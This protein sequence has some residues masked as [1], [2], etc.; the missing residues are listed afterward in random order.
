MPNNL[1]LVSGSNTYAGQVGTVYP[2]TLN[3]SVNQTGNFKAILDGLNGNADLQLQSSSGTV[4]R[5]SSLTGTTPEEINF[6]DLAAGE[7][8]LLV[9]SAGDNINY[10]LSLTLEEVASSEK[11]VVDP[12][13]GSDYEPSTTIISNNSSEISTDSPDLITGDAVEN[14]D[15]ISPSNTLTGTTDETN[16]TEEFTQTD[17][18]LGITSETEKKLG[19]SLATPEEYSNILTTPE[20]E[21]TS[22]QSII[23]ESEI[24]D[25]L[26]EVATTDS[27]ESTNPDELEITSETTN[28]DD[29][30]ITSETTNSDD[31]VITS[32]TTNSQETTISTSV[33]DAIT[34][35]VESTEIGNWE[36]NQKETIDQLT[37]ETIAL[38]IGSEIEEEVISNQV[39]NSVEQNET[40][41]TDLTESIAK[42][43]REESS[44]NSTNNDSSA[45]ISTPDENQDL[46]AEEET[47]IET[48][49]AENS[50]IT[51]PTETAIGDNLT[52]EEPVENSS[53]ISDASTEET[54]AVNGSEEDQKAE[55]EAEVSTDETQQDLNPTTIQPE[56]TASPAPFISGKFKVDTTGKVGIDFLLDG[57]FYKGQLAIFSLKGMEKFVPGSEEFIKEATARALSQSV[58][59]HVVIYDLTE[60]ARFSGN[61]GEENY[62]TGEYL[63]VKTFDMTPGD[64][65]GVML[66]PNG[67]VQE[68]FDN[69][70]ISGDKRPLFSMATANPLHGMQIGQIADVTGEGNTFSMEDLRI[71]GWIDRD[72]NDFVFQVRG[73][74]GK[75]VL[76]DDVVAEGK[77]WRTS[78]LGKA[79]VAYAKPYITPEPAEDLE[80]SLSGLLEDLEDVT[81]KPETSTKELLTEKEDSPTTEEFIEQSSAN[82][83]DNSTSILPSDNQESNPD[84]QA[85]TGGEEDE[86][87][88]ELPPT[89]IPNSATSNT[90]FA[91]DQTED[92]NSEPVF[93]TQDE[94]TEDKP[95]LTAAFEVEKAINTE[96]SL[97]QP[98][99]VETTVNQSEITPTI[100]SKETA[101][102]PD[103]VVNITV[104]SNPPSTQVAAPT[105]ASMLPQTKEAIADTS[106]LT[107]V[108]EVV[109]PL[110]KETV[111][112]I[113]ENTTTSPVVNTSEANAGSN[114][115]SETVDNSVDNLPKKKTENSTNS[116]EDVTPTSEIV[117]EFFEPE[118]ETETQGFVWDWS[119]PFMEEAETELSIINPVN[120]ELIYR[121]ETLSEILRNQD[122][123]IS[124]GGKAVNPALIE[125]LDNIAANLRNQSESNVNPATYDATANLISRLEDMVARVAPVPIEYVEPVQ[126]AFP[127]SSQP[128]VGIIDTGFN[129][130][131]PDIDYSRIILGRDRVSN[132]ENPL[133]A[134]GEGSEHGT[135]ILGILGA[136]QNNGIGID[137]VNDIA[138]LW[139]GRAI[140]SGKWAES[141]V[142]FVDKLRE[143]GQPNGVVNLSLDLTQINPDG[144]VTT[145]YEFTPEERS[146]IEYARQ[147]H[148]LLV[149][150]S[151]NDGSVMSALGQGSQEFDNIITVGAAKRVNDEIALSK[152]YDRADYSSY[153]RGLDIMADG[154]TVENPVFS[155]TGDG[156]GAMAGTSVATA[157]VTGAV[158][159]MWAANPQ[160]SYRQVIDILKSTATDLKEPNWDEETGAGLLNMAA[161]VGL[162]GVTTGEVYQPD[163][164]FT[165]DTWSGEGLAIA[166]ERATATEFMGKYYEWDSYTIKPGDTLSAIAFS[167]MGNSSAPYYN[168][169][170]EKNGIT[171]PNLIYVGQNIGSFGILW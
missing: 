40:N 42:E 21:S 57:G 128:L 165:P 70:A 1:G 73:A 134:T 54:S 169:I 100:E 126:F 107:S 24:P 61:S 168:F 97:V 148:V 5:S 152:A 112:T 116:I 60:G 161:A 77:D 114:Q 149:V 164:W 92:I 7:Y 48:P 163:N 22:E 47:T 123:E 4:L 171:N 53:E 132:D 138:P 99:V 160:L 13:T 52:T 84:S 76:M 68:V 118:L 64:E 150:S 140:G 6:S 66:I 94:K 9:I 131:N 58:E 33:D 88:E 157:K 18:E 108:A 141:L 103:L 30:E 113:S 55:Y 120:A 122:T 133:L 62:N 51:A 98:N 79:L 83:D 156:V 39:T 3:F 72:Y 91:S 136:T 151:G 71:D 74:I 129:G 102:I 86:V 121:V 63:G 147:N 29:L 43:N 34:N 10:S 142:E 146:A 162:A 75:A 46:L 153:G 117:S 26:A 19:E 25:D 32:E 115:S 2:D 106:N 135:H 93:L 127:F 109:T 158:S 90:E 23:S 85:A 12:L 80:T 56:L 31:S 8:S 15:T 20:I 96:D 101:G 59:G 27:H 78:D 119:L 49:L 124:S 110:T 170:A 67:T 81:L 155:T 125:R 37:G 87:K 104:S 38:E 89:E 36:S 139:V 130:N 41:S 143:S 166:A 95:K 159:Q 105:S 28:S 111:N 144:S 154:G 65:F 35:N 69:P 17:S 137:G 145:R 45:T 16:S 167:T 50:I 44:S 82:S 14:Q 11:A